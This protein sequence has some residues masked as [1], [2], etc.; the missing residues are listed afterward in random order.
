MISYYKIEDV[1]NGRLRPPSSLP[2]LASL[3]IS[4]EY[5]DKTHFR[6]PPKV[7]IGSDGVPRYRG[8]ADEVDS[9]SPLLT[10][11]SSPGPPLLGNGD[12]PEM[13][14]VTGRRNRYEP[15]P[16]PERSRRSAK[17]GGSST[18]P[19]QPATVSPPAIYAESV[20]ALTPTAP[21]TYQP[22][23]SSP[24]GA[25]CPFPGYPLHAQG[26]HAY[27][28]IQHTTS[29]GMVT[30]QYPYPAV[31]ATHQL[32][33]DTAQQQHTQVYYP[34]L[35]QQ[36]STYAGMPPTYSYHTVPPA[37]AQQS[38]IATHLEQTDA[39]PSTSGEGGD[40]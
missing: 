6:N 17:P 34:Y 35:P 22:Y 18:P 23:G 2:E 12:V 5:L 38:S 13:P 4:P 16:A 25:Y 15:Y 19:E 30:Y 31:S 33:S 39:P 24:Y 32:P 28:P 36:H 40:G 37:H 9:S 27:Y 7:E 1:Q 14:N 20:S 10:T 3:N 21:Y 26:P 8:E 29:K 11:P